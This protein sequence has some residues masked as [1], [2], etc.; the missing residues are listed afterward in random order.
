VKPLRSLLA[1]ISLVIGTIALSTNGD[2]AVAGLAYAQPNPQNPGTAT[3]TPTVRTVPTSITSENAPNATDATGVIP[4]RYIVVLVDSVNDPETAAKELSQRHGFAYTYVYENAFKG[5]AGVIP[6][7]QLA[8]VRSDPRVLF[9]DPVRMTRL[10]GPPQAQGVDVQAAAARQTQQA[11]TGLRRISGSNNGVNQTLINKGT[12]VGVAVLDTG[13]QL[14]HPDLINPNGQR[15]VQDGPNYSAWNGQGKC[16]AGKKGSDDDNGHGT[17]VAGII[18]ARDN[19]IGAVGVA[20]EATLYAVKIVD[21]NG[22]GTTDQAACGVDWVALNAA[23]IKVANM[24]IGAR[25]SDGI[26]DRSTCSDPSALRRAVCGAVQKG[27]TFVVASGN[28]STDASGSA[29]AAYSEVITVSAIADANGAPGGGGFFSVGCA[30]SYL[31]LGRVFDEQ[32]DYA[33]KFSNFGAPVDIA[34]PGVC[35]DSLWKGNGYAPLSGTSQAS[36]FVTGA[37]ALYMAANPQA[38]PLQVKL[39]LMAV[40]EAGPIPGDRD[41][42]PQF[43]EGIIDL[44]VVPPAQPPS[45]VFTIQPTSSQS[46]TAFPSQPVVAVRFGAITAT[47]Y[48]GPVKLAIKSG[49]GTS[50]A[51]LSGASMVNAVNGVATFSGLSIDKAGA[52]YI[53]TAVADDGITSGESAAFTVFTPNLAFTIQ[54]SGAGAGSPFTTQPAVAAKDPSNN[55]VT[56]FTGSVTLAIKSGTG[57]AGAVLSGTKAVNAVNGVATFSDL[58]IDKAGTGYVLAASAPGT[59]GSASAP[60]NVDPAVTPDSWTALPAA[61]APSPRYGHAAFW[62][63]S[64]MIVWGGTSTTQAFVD[65]GRYRP[66]TNTWVPMATAGAPSPRSGYSAIWTGSE[67][68]VWGGKSD[69]NTVLADGARYNPSSDSWTPLPPAPISERSGASVIWTGTEMII[70]GGGGYFW[71]CGTN[72]SICNDG[73][74]YNPTTNTWVPLSQVNV[75][76]PR[77]GHAAVW[78]GSEMI[79]WGGTGYVSFVG[80]TTINDGA[81]YNPST[82]TWTPITPSPK[83]GTTSHT[84]LWTGS[85]MITWGGICGSCGGLPDAEKYKPSNDTW[86][87]IADD[88]RYAHAGVWTGSEAIVWGGLGYIGVMHG[89]GLRYSPS[90]G[91]IAALSMSNAPAPRFG[92]TAVWTGSEMIVWGGFDFTNVFGDGSR[93][94]P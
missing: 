48:N 38:K 80:Y 75:P 28:E 55:T 85:D 49:T 84:T 69:P 4:N 86:T 35:I 37:A 59:A 51:A 67:M 8:A 47:G 23:S 15:A 22:D 2:Q 10:I 42:N 30:A 65:G 76:A 36:P 3:P 46:T 9:I 31:K 6:R 20:P 89:D 88:P 60:F 18:A 79:I 61:G 12:G 11:S 64:E 34:A 70:W 58:S 40:Q 77:S 94:N 44:A 19:S 72:L 74:R 16:S 87:G 43:K 45:L 82:A 13:I 73:A 92:H 91:T 33:A 62:T 1:A 5:F 26:A 24:S 71:S 29:P 27:I 63:G 25:G 57:T 21:R 14:D 50:G 68:I 32:D 90:S 83:P 53:L 39:A 54:P 78:T 56:S 52:G 41:T 66:A 7:P 81:R 17:H 93:Y